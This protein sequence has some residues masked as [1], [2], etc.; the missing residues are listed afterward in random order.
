MGDV[1]TDQATIDFA[2][3]K[4]KMVNLTL[5]VED[6][7]GGYTEETMQG[8]V[9]EGNEIGLIFKRRSQR[10]QDLVEAAD[11]LRIEVVDTAR[12]QAIG[13]KHL[14]PITPTSIRR[15]LV[16]FHGMFRADVEALSLEEAMKMH[17]KIDHEPLGHDHSDTGPKPV[18]DDRDPEKDTIL[19]RISELARTA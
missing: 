6:G 19:S 14:R 8:R 18:T 12:L 2:Q 11:V 5:R 3:F 10:T 4:S 15:H 9:I 1:S 16:D 7:K 17:A 13:Q